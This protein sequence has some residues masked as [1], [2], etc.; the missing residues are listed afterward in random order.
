MN[1]DMK[2]RLFLKASLASGAVG[3]AV[4]TGLLTP[5]AVLAARSVAAFNAESLDGAVKESMGSDIMTDSAEITLDIPDNP[6]NGAVVPVAVATTLTGVESIALLVEKNIKPLC[7]VFYPGK[8]M[9]SA[10]SIRIKVGESADVI[11]VVKSD[12]K[13]YSARKAVKVTIGG[14]G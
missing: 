12:G 1:T 11:A 10:L 2:R 13:L 5:R 9:K 7:G 14:C 4:G 6:E 3:I 8:R